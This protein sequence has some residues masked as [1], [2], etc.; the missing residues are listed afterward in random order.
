[1]TTSK[2]LLETRMDVGKLPIQGTY[3]IGH[4]CEC[5]GAKPRMEDHSGPHPMQVLINTRLQDGD[6]S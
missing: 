4:A 2:L 3:L 6:T 1:M 5:G